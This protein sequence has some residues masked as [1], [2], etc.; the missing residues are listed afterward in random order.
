MNYIRYFLYGALIVVALMLWNAW[1][2]EHQATVT[3][4]GTTITQQSALPQFKQSQLPTQTTSKKKICHDPADR[5]GV[6]AVDF[7]SCYVLHWNRGDIRTEIARSYTGT[8][9]RGDEYFNPTF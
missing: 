8:E 3:K 9:R 5:Y 7:F 6:S 1:Q 4:P 2:Q